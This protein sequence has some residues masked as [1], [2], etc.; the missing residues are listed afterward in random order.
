ML[1]KNGWLYPPPKVYIA[2][3]PIHGLGVFANEDIS[4]GE[5]IEITP[6]VDMEMAPDDKSKILFD[7]R[8]SY[9]VDGKIT[10]LVMPMG[11]G[12]IYNHS[13]AP[14]AN[15]R[16]NVG[17]DMFEFYSIRDIKKHEEICTSYGNE[18]YWKARSH[19][20]VK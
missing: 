11:Y 18:E 12:C 13:N 4:K 8:F 1:I 20:K 16:L 10:K 7:Y 17:L 19:V 15:W 2:K 5:V 3:S 14:N 6:L 9:I